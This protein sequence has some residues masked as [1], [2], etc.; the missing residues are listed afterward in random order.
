MIAAQCES[1]S[2]DY[3]YCKIAHLSNLAIFGG[4]PML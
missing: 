2:M 3:F 1:G 4:E